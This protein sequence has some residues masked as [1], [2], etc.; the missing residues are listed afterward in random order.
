MTEE[1]VYNL[2]LDECYAHHFDHFC[3]AGVIIE[4]KKYETDVIPALKALKQSVFGDPELILHHSEL[5]RPTPQFKAMRDKAKRTE[6][7]QGISSILLMDDVYGLA[8]AIK[9]AKVMDLYPKM[10]DSYTVAFQ[11][12]VENF[13]NFLERNNAKGNIIME[14]RN[15]REDRGLINKFNGL[16]Y[17]GTLFY[18]ADVIHDHLGGI[19][20][21]L[22]AENSIGLQLADIFPLIINRDLQGSHCKHPLILSSVKQVMCHSDLTPEEQHLSERFGLKKVPS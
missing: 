21:Y 15:T 13:V 19:N 14:S 20:F 8:V 12:I 18:H 6:Y 5:S 16:K 4:E 7:E 9:E 17:T 10:K 1:K 11:L 2:Y 3:L 22:K